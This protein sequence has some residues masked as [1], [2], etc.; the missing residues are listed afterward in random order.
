MADIDKNNSES[1][2]IG[3]EK[4]DVNLKKVFLYGILGI[5]LLIIVIIFVVDQFSAM[6]EEI[7]YEQVLRPE[8]APL[9][10]LR[11]REIEELGSYKLLN[12]ADS[13]F[14]IPI[15]RAKQLTADEAYRERMAKAG[16]Q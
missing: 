2:D 13:V 1:H 6:K 14:R 16:K 12:S 3:Y 5:I 8:S 11:A 7:V 9:R 15:E 10:E 4:S